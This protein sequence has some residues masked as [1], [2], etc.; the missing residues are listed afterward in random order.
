ME[1]LN[2]KLQTLNNTKDW[3]SAV[4]VVSSVC[5]LF[6]LEMVEDPFLFQHPKINAR[7]S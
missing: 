7:T 2:K 6:G 5:G 3:Q 1:E 4:N